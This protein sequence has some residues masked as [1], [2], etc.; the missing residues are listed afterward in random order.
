METKTVLP[1]K[2]ITLSDQ[3][4]VNLEVATAINITPLSK[5]NPTE[6]CVILVGKTGKTAYVDDK[7]GNIIVYKSIA[8]AKARLKL[9]CDKNK[10]KVISQLSI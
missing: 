9:Y 1:K 3:T 7:D 8:A 5:T 10:I 2:R 6:Y 4:K